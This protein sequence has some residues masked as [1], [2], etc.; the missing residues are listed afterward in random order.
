VPGAD[1]YLPIPVTELVQ[2]FDF[3]PDTCI[4]LPSR[5]APLD[6]EAL[7]LLLEVPHAYLGVIGSRRRWASVVEGLTARGIGP[8][9]LAR[10]HAP[11]GLELGAETPEEIALSVLAEIVMLRRQG[12][13]RSM[14]GQVTPE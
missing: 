5:G 1:A 2:R 12:T 3:Q 11:M 14:R 7:P 6:I 8:E 13:G 10:V 4:V 9:K